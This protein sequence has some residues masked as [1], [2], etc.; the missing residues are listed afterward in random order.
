MRTRAAD[1]EQST[2]GPRRSLGPSENRR[3]LD[4][5]H[6]PR[7]VR[8]D[9]DLDASLDARLKLQGVWRELDAAGKPTAR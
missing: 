4:S 8:G 1:L 6:E 7:L 3:L 9:F 5:A 2:G